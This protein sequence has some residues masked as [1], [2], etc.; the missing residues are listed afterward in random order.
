MVSEQIIGISVRSELV[1][2]WIVEIVAL[3]IVQQSEEQGML[4]GGGGEHALY[5]HLWIHPW[6]HTLK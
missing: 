4:W 5:A 3:T 1:L 6:A 2:V